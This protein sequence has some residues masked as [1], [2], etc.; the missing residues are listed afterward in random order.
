MKQGWLIYSKN[1]M[2]GNRSY[3][4]WFIE[5][6]WFANLKLELILREE[7]TVG[8]FNNERA[9]FLRGEATKP[10]FAVIR[11]IDPMLNMHLEAFGITVF[12]SSYIACICNDK[13]L[14]H[15]HMNNLGIPMVNTIFIKKQHT[16]NQPPVPYPFVVKETDGRGG[17]QV[18][19]I[20]NNQEWQECRNQTV[21]NEL[22]LQSCDVQPGKDIRVF[23]IGN[24]IVGAVLRKNVKD[25][26]ANYKLGGSAYWYNL[27]VKERKMI[28][29][30]TDH[31]SFDFAGIDFLIGTDG[32]ILLNEIEDVVGSRTLSAVSNINTLQQYVTHIK[33]RLENDA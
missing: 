10:D 16:T 25:F 21:A 1:D 2:N 15:H 29:K 22:I 30:I 8:I 5:E 4:N 13:A 19:L 17:K 14:T 12:N 6:A 27:N 18:Y 28:Q 31:F 33:N 32:E 24:E 7:L 23:I 11:T 26:R 3:I 20:K 9:V